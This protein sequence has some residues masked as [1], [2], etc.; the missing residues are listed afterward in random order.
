[1]KN[2]VFAS[3]GALVF[4]SS[5]FGIAPSVSAD[6]VIAARK[7]SRITPYSLVS[8]GYQGFFKAQGIP[9]ASLFERDAR[10]GRLTAIE[11][12][13]AGIASGRLSE[14][15]LEDRSYVEAVGD[16]LRRVVRN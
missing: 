14:S 8:S 9:S 6:E 13:E 5:T 16:V 10:V 7:G 2:L 3:V 11:L 1:M 12:I 15:A 4:A